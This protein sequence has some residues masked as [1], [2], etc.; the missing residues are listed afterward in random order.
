MYIFNV[1][2][3]MKQGNIVKLQ[4]CVPHILGFRDGKHYLYGPSQ[5][6][7][8]TMFLRFYPVPDHTP[9]LGG[10]HNNIQLEVYCVSMCKN[11]VPEA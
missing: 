8:R 2:Q 9:L 10:S 4:F 3:Y 5:I 7:I 6:P 1:S 11:E